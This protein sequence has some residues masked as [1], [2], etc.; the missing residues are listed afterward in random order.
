MLAAVTI[1]FL[2]TST[3]SNHM[4]LMAKQRIA[5]AVLSTNVIKINQERYTERKNREIVWLNTSSKSL[6]WSTLSRNKYM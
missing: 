6:R 2:F 4:K 5:I 3:R 1:V